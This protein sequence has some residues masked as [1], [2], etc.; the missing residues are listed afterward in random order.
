MG[1]TPGQCMRQ[2]LP[3]TNNSAQTVCVCVCA[4]VRVCM[5]VCAH[6]PWVAE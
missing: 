2:V 1:S 4:C 6:V 5:H 3:P